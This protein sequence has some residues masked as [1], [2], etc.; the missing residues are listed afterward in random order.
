VTT[1]TNLNKPI[2]PYTASWLDQLPPALIVA[3]LVLIAAAGIVTISRLHLAPTMV[4]APTP[5][6]IILIATAPAMVV[7]TA[8]PPAAQVAAVV[9]N[10]LRRAV[11]AYDAPAGNV[12]GAI[13]QGRAY[14]MVARFGA[15]WLQADVTGSGL[16]W[17]RADQV[18]DLPADLVDL[19]PAPQPQVI[20]QQVY[21]NQP[22]PVPTYAALVVE[23]A[24]QVTNS[25]P[26]AIQTAP[27]PQVAPAATPVPAAGPSDVERAW[28]KEELREEHPEWNR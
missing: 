14:R 9:P 7:P 11:V 28:I 20:Y 27:A 13:E 5:G 2:T 4:P 8:L 3:V 18:L 10:A 17:L 26:Q 1:T 25:A 21:A 16:V 15:D 23:L 24:Y 6:L 22:A 19:A 12:I